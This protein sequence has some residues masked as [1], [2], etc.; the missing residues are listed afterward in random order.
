MINLDTFEKLS[1]KLPA[2]TLIQLKTRLL[3]ATAITAILGGVER[4]FAIILH[5]FFSLL[6]LYG[7]KNNKK[8]YLSLAILAHSFVDFFPGL[9]QMHVITNILVVEALVMILR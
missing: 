3:Q 5:I 6:V 1:G 8:I 2:A 9:Y 4:I 7:V